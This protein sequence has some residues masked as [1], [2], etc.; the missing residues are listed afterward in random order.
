[1]ATVDP[2][3]KV[4][5][6]FDV[7]T[8]PEQSEELVPVE[9]SSGMKKPFVAAVA[10]F[11]VF[12]L[13]V[14][15]IAI[16]ALVFALKSI[17]EAQN[18]QTSSEGADAAAAAALQKADGNP[19]IAGGLNSS[20][21]SESA[22][23]LGIEGQSKTW[24]GTSNN[25]YNTAGDVALWATGSTTIVTS[26]DGTSLKFSQKGYYTVKA[27]LPLSFNSATL[28][29][30]WNWNLT[31]SAGTNRVGSIPYCNN[32]PPPDGTTA[33]TIMGDSGFYVP[34]VGSSL[35]L[36]GS[37]KGSGSITLSGTGLSVLITK[38]S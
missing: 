29:S 16:V 3:V 7:K 25:G 18:A 13:I 5:E 1:M 21:A 36:R 27:N 9:E 4:P 24:S 10:T 14:L 11:S 19:A 35:V 2:D 32:F 34:E 26:A 15:V 6:T 33:V 17:Q 8:P 20:K 30:A 23:V 31:T 37:F 38:F 22:T 12:I 28:A